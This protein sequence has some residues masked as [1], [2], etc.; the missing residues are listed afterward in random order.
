MSSEIMHK[1]VADQLISA[2]QS[3]EDFAGSTYYKHL[4]LFNYYSMMTEAL[5][6][7]TALIYPTAPYDKDGFRNESQLSLNSAEMEAICKENV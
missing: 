5:K 6:D 7:T 2:F 4:K 1:S 3:F